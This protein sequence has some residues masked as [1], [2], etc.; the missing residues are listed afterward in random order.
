MLPSRATAPARIFVPPRSTPI[1]L[2]SSTGGTVNPDGRLRGEAV[3]RIQGRPIEG[4]GSAA[5]PRPRR[6]PCG[7]QRR[8]RSGEG[9]RAGQGAQTAL[10]R[11]D[12][13]ALDA[14]HDPP[15]D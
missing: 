1:A 3:P 2:P 15:A 7:A 14:R 11:L 5:E 8:R 12:V 4:E 9:R 10:V 6:A 13:A